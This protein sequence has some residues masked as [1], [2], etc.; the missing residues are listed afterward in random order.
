MDGTSVF[1]GPSGNGFVPA[2]EGGRLT[3]RHRT[4]RPSKYPHF[5]AAKIG[6]CPNRRAA[7]GIRAARPP[8]G[9]QRHVGVR[10]LVSLSH[11]IGPRLSGVPLHGYETCPNLANRRLSEWLTG[12]F[13]DAT[14]AA[15][16]KMIAARLGSHQAPTTRQDPEAVV[17]SRAKPCA[18]AFGA[19]VDGAARQMTF[20]MRLPPSSG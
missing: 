10:G 13:P 8:R 3:V 17:Q 14:H 1:V 6:L 16:T 18:F 2:V 11:N 9:S 20:R 5:S 7:Q 12:S 15:V 4:H 19:L